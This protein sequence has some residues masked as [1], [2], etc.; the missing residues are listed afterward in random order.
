MST[1][2]TEE[3]IE[4]ARDLGACEP[5]L[6]WLDAAPRRAVLTGADLAGADLIGADLRDQ[7]L[8]GAHL[9]DAV[10]DPNPGQSP[11]KETKI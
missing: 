9:A 4:R 7:D 6:A 11:E 1:P 8:R 2:I 3:Q 10:Y 5:A